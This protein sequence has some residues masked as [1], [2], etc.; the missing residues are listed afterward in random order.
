M[1]MPEE[2][3]LPSAP[4]T[5][6]ASPCRFA[7]VAADVLSGKERLSAYAVALGKRRYKRF[8][9]LC[10]GK[11]R[12]PVKFSVAETSGAFPLK[13][14]RNGRLP[15]KGEGG[16]LAFGDKWQARATVSHVL[17]L[18]LPLR[19]EMAGDHFS[20]TERFRLNSII[21]NAFQK[22]ASILRRSRL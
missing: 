14:Y 9:F 2:I 7:W 8:V 19:G 3:A 12:P 11:I 22:T 13:R 20:G 10:K 5:E 4:G 18:F 1:E 21:D 15:Y 17:I 6:N 16:A